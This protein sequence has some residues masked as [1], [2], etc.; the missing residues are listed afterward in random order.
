MSLFISFEGGEG[1]GKS[2]QAELLR[3][4]LVAAGHR[5]LA[6]QE[7]GGTE[8]GSYLRSWLK[9]T[10]KPL[11]PEAELFLFVA[12]RS[13]LVRRVIRPALESGATVIADRYADST[14]VYQGY[15][16]RLPL[17][18]VN[19]A[20]ALATDGLWPHLTVLLDA[21]PEVTFHR[22][23]LRP[24]VDDQGGPGLAEA[25]PESEQR[26]FEEASPRFH[27]RV[28]QGYLKLAARQP[29][30]WAVVDASQP[31][32]AVAALVWE[33]VERLLSARS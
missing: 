9:A 13:E 15:G 33:R 2:T 18:S 17:R 26:R 30:R 4:M 6:V 28:H 3:E 19:S 24:S 12:A 31:P 11:T 20:N 22:A 23:Q 16:R 8:L 5:V 14:T 10:K 21:P 7:P 29:R 27:R 25:P 32:E 1:S